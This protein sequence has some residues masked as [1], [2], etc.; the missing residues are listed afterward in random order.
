M[1]IVCVYSGPDRIIRASRHYE[2]AGQIITRMGVA[3]AKTFISGV[4][5]DVPP[6]GED[7]VVSAPGT[8]DRV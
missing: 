2:R 6:I 7:V 3:T 5:C 1:Y 8:Y 4:T